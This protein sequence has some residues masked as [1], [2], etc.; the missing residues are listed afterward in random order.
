M[1]SKGRSPGSQDPYFF[2][3]HVP[4]SLVFA[5][6]IGGPDLPVR[7]SAFARLLTHPVARLSP[8]RGA[9]AAS[10]KDQGFRA[11]TRF[12]NKGL[13]FLSPLLTSCH[14]DPPFRVGVWCCADLQIDH[15]ATQS[16]V[17][18]R[19]Y[20]KLRWVFRQGTPEP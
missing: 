9:S 6:G 15:F 13:Q 16:S 19:A 17:S 10:A 20:G 5:Y 2:W 11:F 8:E 4:M 14:T 7:S 18:M 12:L 3:Q 1:A